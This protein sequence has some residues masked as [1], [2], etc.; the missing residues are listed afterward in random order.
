MRRSVTFVALLRNTPEP[1]VVLPSAPLLPEIVPP[2]ELPPTA[3]L[4]PSPTTVKLPL[5]FES[6]M[7]FAVPP[8]ELMLVNVRFK[9]VVL[10]LRVI[11][12]A[13]APLLLIVPLVAV[14]VVV[15]L[16]ARSALSF[17]SGEISR[18]ANVIAP[19]FVVRLTPVSPEPLTEVLA[20]PSVRLE[21][22]TLIPM[23]VE[24]VTVVE[25]V[26]KEPPTPVRLRPVVALFEEERLPKVPLRVPV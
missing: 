23:P 18:S 4:A 25:P 8:E 24:F 19:V 12:T 17:A 2:V 22:S 26:L 3:V 1:L 14:M 15:L 11:S 21:V 6:V 9:G 7:P 13:V 16:V 20:K 5:V 10:L